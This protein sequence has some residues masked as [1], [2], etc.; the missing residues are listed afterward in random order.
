MYRRNASS[1]WA[2]S[3]SCSEAMRYLQ[4]A[5]GRRADHRT[6]AH[7]TRPVCQPLPDCGTG[8]RLL[9]GPAVAVVAGQPG[10]QGPAGRLGVGVAHDL[11]VAHD[12]RGPDHH[13]GRRLPGRGLADPE[14]LVAHHRDPA[15]LH[16]H[17]VG[18]VDLDVAHDGGGDDVDVAPRHLGA[19]QVEHHVPHEG[20]RGQR[21]LDPP[22]SLPLAVPHDGDHPLAV[23]PG[24]RPHRGRRSTRGL[25]QVGGEGPQL[26][27]GG[28]RVGG[29]GPLG[30]LPEGQPAL[31][32]GLPQPLHRGLALGIG[33][34]DL[35]R[36][37]L[38][39]FVAHAPTIRRPAAD[40]TPRVWQSPRRGDPVRARSGWRWGNV[41]LPETYLVGLGAGLLL[42]LVVPWR[43]PWPAGAGRAVGWPCCW[44]AWGWRRGRCGRPP[45]CAWNAPTGWSGAG[46]MPSAAT[47]CT[48]PRPPPT[49]GSPWWPAPPGRCCSCPACWRPPTSW[50]SARS[51]P[52]KPASV[53]P[54]GATEARSASTCDRGQAVLGARSGDRSAGGRA[55]RCLTTYPPAPE[56][57]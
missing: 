2:R 18:D 10:A 6:P 39:G 50:S 37:P 32:G 21:P 54:T 12:R 43:P 52:W 56:D 30:Q 35:G 13:P 44:P 33:G 16:V 49:W 46:P 42:Q 38:A 53:P 36:V 41:P 14:L 8:G 34:P 11:D 29:P 20:D 45:R 25:G 48:A 22:P 55:H 9:D 26:A 27:A 19:A 7:T 1:C 4:A 57:G 23:P 47:R 24:G 51:G 31:G 15:Q 40:D 17:A 3:S 28:G 5:P